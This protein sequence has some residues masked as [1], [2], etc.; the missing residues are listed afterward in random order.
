MRDVATHGL[1]ADLLGLQALCGRPAGELAQVDRIRAPRARGRVAAV[2]VLVEELERGL[3][4][5]F[6]ATVVRRCGPR[7]LPDPATAPLS[8]RRR[9]QPR[10]R[11]AWRT[12][13]SPRRH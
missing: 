13:G 4:W 2:Q 5:G 8:A 7:T 6:H 3:P 9:L 1:R 10:C 12:S 11:R